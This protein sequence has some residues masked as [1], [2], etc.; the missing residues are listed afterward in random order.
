MSAP[1]SLPARLARRATEALILR[2]LR[3]SFRRVVWIGDGP[4]PP[5]NRPVVLYANHHSFYD[6]YLLWLLVRS[7]LGRPPVL[8]MEQLQQAPLFG[9]VGALPFPPDDDRQRFRTIRETARRLREEPQT[10]LLFFPEGKLRATDL[11]LGPFQT[12]FRQLARLLP[13]NTL[14]W[15]VALRATWWG[16]DR[17]TAL[18]TSAN[19]LETPSGHERE[20]LQTLLDDLSNI[21][22]A[23][24][25]EGGARL[26]LDDRKSAEERWDL[27]RLAPLF[28]RWT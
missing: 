11:G 23:I 28:R 26:L 20:D 13:D 27:S 25:Q 5:E 15:P 2:D 24:M 10:I 19:P 22:P 6:G 14:W 12:N 9:P 17:P 7:A 1:S 18:L 3:R 16:E 4:E 8:W 21:S